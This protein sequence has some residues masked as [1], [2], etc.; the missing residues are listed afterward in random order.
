[1]RKMMSSGIR[2]GIVGILLVLA[3]PLPTDA[4]SPESQFPTVTSTEVIPY[5]NVRIISNDAHYYQEVL[6]YST[7]VDTVVDDTLLVSYGLL[8][9]SAGWSPNNEYLAY[10]NLDKPCTSPEDEDNLFLFHPQD[11]T[12]SRDCI[13]YDFYQVGSVQWSPSDSNLLAIVGPDQLYDVTSQTLKPFTFPSIPDVATSVGYGK[14]L[15]DSNTGQPV[16]EVRLNQKF[17]FDAHPAGLITH[18]VFE[19]C[20]AQCVPLVDTLKVA[21]VDV[22]GW[23]LYGHWLLWGCGW[24][25]TGLPTLIRSVSDIENTAVY[26]TDLTTDQTQ[27]LFRFS[28]LGSTDLRTVDLGWSPDAAT[29]ALALYSTAPFDDGD[30]LPTPVPGLN[31]PRLYG[32]QLLHLTWPAAESTP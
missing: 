22:S 24:S 2:F 26:L 30:L 10:M 31:H 3:A 23:Q 5:D 17:D 29:I 8:W 16:A 19:A 1:M 4:Q 18:S 21:D 9:A 12:L 13:P 15:W 32:T 28:S 20:A 14:L 6:S 7:V 25:T 27:E 11:G